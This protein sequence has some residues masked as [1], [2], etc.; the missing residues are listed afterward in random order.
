MILPLL[1]TIRR[2]LART[3]IVLVNNHDSERRK[4][5]NT[6]TLVTPSYRSMELRY[7]CDALD[8]AVGTRRLSPRMEPLLDSAALEQ[9]EAQPLH[10]GA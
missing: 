3:R 9:G 2:D 7:D 10:A 5:A 6:L 1:V 4:R 8:E